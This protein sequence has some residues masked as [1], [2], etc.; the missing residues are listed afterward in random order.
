[1]GKFNWHFEIVH[2]ATF[3]EKYDQQAEEKTESLFQLK[4]PDICFDREKSL[5]CL[6]IFWP[7]IC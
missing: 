4:M 7:K 2:Y 3:D 5:V 1:M 6:N